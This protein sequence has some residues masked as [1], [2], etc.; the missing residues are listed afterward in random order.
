MKAIVQSLIDLRIPSIAI[1]SLFGFL[2]YH[3]LETVPPMNSSR[4]LGGV[5]CLSVTVFCGIYA[6]LEHLIKERYESII[7]IQQVAMNNLSKTHSVY[8]D[9][10]Q[11]TITKTV[12]SESTDQYIDVSQS[13]VTET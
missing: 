11:R 7:D 6:F 2:T 1:L 12:S 8:E 10:H 3:L 5:I 4:G 13:T 9:S